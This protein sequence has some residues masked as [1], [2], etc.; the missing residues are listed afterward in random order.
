MAFTGL[1]LTGAD[2][3]FAD[4]VAQ[5]ATG[6]NLAADAADTVAP[7]SGSTSAGA[8]NAKRPV[9]M[10]NRWQ[11]DWS[12]LANPCVPREPLDGLKYIPFGGDPA[13]YLSLGV[14]MRE[15]VE[16]N[17]AP[18]FG[19]GTQSDTY[20]I[21]RVEV[22]ADAHLGEHWQF[23]VQIEDAR[24]WGKNVVTPV[25]KNPLDLEQAFVTYTGALGGGT[26]KFRVGRQEMA[27]D[28]QR[29]ISVRDGPN[30]RQT[31]D[32]LWADYEYQKW[33]FIAYATQPV[34]NRDA[35]AF[36]DVSNRDLTFSGVRFERQSVGPGDLSG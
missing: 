18:L 11:E 23:F 16:T 19:I 15:R 6:M 20:L 3:A 29:F 24:V 4:T 17:N 21:Q 31:Y 36:D 2:A 9:V 32:A 14:N 13:S 26:F 25:D 5:P 12:V 34:Q 27:F 30:V 33:R 22:H 1:L 8:C 10:F 7:A 35:T 28:L